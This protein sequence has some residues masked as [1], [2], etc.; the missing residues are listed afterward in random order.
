MA[1]HDTGSAVVGVPVEDIGGKNTE[2]KRAYLSLGTWSLMG[3]EIEEPII[4]EE[5][6]KLNFTNEYI[7]DVDDPEF[8]NPKNMISTIQMNSEKNNQPIPKSIGQITRC[9]GIRSQRNSKN[10]P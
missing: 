5:V 9:I 3:V 8:F 2:K 7:I 10:N 1:S 4:N 6:K